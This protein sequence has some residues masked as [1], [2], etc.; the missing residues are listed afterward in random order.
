MAWREVTLETRKS[1][2]QVEFPFGIIQAGLKSGSRGIRDGRP[3][4]TSR[5]L[6]RVL[7]GLLA[8]VLLTD[9]VG[10]LI[11]VRADR[12]TLG[13]AWGSHAT[14]AAPLPMMVAQGV[15]VLLL[16]R[17]GRRTAIGAAGLLTLACVV[18]FVSG[19]FD[20][21]LGR[22]DL[23]AGEV[24]FQ[25]WLISLTLVLGIAAALTGRRRAR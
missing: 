7:V 17:A 4:T 25:V 18:S 14:L 16:L 19:F 9:V 11:D 3:M 21:Q 2:D 12:S 10:G 5:L 15:M 1:R 6:P 22:S 8:V 20:G 23:A 24:A 13:S